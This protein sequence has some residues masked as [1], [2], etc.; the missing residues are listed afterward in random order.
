MKRNNVRTFLAEVWKSLQKQT[1]DAEVYNFAYRVVFAWISEV[2]TDFRQTLQFE[3]SDMWK[4]NNLDFRKKTAEAPP[5][6]P[7]SPRERER[8]GSRPLPWARIGG[9]SA[10]LF[11]LP[12]PR[13]SRG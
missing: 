1:S 4:I 3:T 12:N 7:P 13:A 5:H 8:A 10:R 6:T 2:K 11:L 9:E